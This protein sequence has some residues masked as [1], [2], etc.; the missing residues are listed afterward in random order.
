MTEETEVLY[1]DLTMDELVAKQAV[2]KE[3]LVELEPAIMEKD[4]LEEDSEWV[5]LAMSKY[6]TEHGEPTPKDL[7]SL[8]LFASSKP[9]LHD[10][11][12]IWLERVTQS[13]Q[14]TLLPDEDN[15][16]GSSDFYWVPLAVDLTKGVT[17]ELVKDI[18][19]TSLAFNRNRYHE[20]KTVY[21]F[22]IDL[23]LIVKVVE[24]D[25]GEPTYIA[26]VGDRNS[27]MF[28]SFKR[29]EALT[30]TEALTEVQA[31]LTKATSNAKK[32]GTQGN[33]TSEGQRKK[34]FGIF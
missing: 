7:W 29:N 21:R 5:N 14:V 28:K 25:E 9:E 34:L 13:G 30:I 15:E 11:F 2:L 12:H 8:K 16:M 17:P 32:D 33:K 31:I 18:E 19:I 4:Q 10:S 23:H 27:H 20:D 1:R 3:R 6:R 26:Y 24:S 22:L